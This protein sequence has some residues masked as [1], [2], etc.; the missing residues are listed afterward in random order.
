[1]LSYENKGQNV[2]RV[3]IERGYAKSLGSLLEALSGEVKQKDNWIEV[4]QENYGFTVTGDNITT[5]SNEA[6][7]FV[8]WS[9]EV[10]DM[11]NGESDESQCFGM[12]NSLK[13]NE[14]IMTP[15]RFEVASI[16]RLCE[17]LEHV[18]ISSWCPGDI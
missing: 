13:W 7:G 2:F 6:L 16:E 15:G 10:E 8:G 3:Y 18:R 11:D 14:V 17:A 1:M 4:S 5:P 12:S 9:D